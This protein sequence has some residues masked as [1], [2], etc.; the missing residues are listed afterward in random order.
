[1]QRGEVTLG[2][3]GEEMVLGVMEERTDVAV[4]NQYHTPFGSR[5]H[6][7][8]SRSSIDRVNRYAHSSPGVFQAHMQAP[9]LTQLS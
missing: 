8:S 7:S 9:S 2:V 6:P 4:K 3:D 1:M 5:C